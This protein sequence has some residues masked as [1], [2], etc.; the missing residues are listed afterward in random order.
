MEDVLQVGVRVGKRFGHV[1][2][3]RK[4]FPEEKSLREENHMAGSSQE[5]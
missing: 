5:H 1:E 3:G 2:I 4:S